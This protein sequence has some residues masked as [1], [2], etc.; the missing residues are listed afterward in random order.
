MTL[1]EQHHLRELP[2]DSL[3]VVGF[4]VLVISL[5]GFIRACFNVAW[6]SWVYLLVMMY[7]IA[8]L[9]GFTIFGFAVT[10]QGGGTLVPGRNYRE[11]KL[12]SYSPWLRSRVT[13]PNYWNS[14]WNCIIGSK[15]CEKMG[16]LTPLD[17][18]ERTM[19]PVQSG[20]CKPL[21]SCTYNTGTMVSFRRSWHKLAVLS[22]LLLVLLICI[23][24]IGCCTFRNTKRAETEY[25]YGENRMR[26]I[27][28]R[29]DYYW[30]RRLH[31]CKERLY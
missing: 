20:C 9:A 11:Y 28:P 25:P 13:D 31:D 30:W 6:A 23:Y 15:A 19:S 2:P 29:W 16:N 18:Y 14:I 21:T 5:A 22:I 4:I 26:K 10:G 27:K 8:A 17:Y 7:L 24:L 12:E 3:L 1:D